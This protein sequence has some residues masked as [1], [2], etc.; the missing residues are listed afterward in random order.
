MFSSVPARDVSHA[1][2]R[3]C[4]SRTSSICRPP[5]WFTAPS[6]DGRT[7]ALATKE[8]ALRFVDVEQRNVVGGP[9]LAG[10]HVRSV[11]WSPDGRHF[12]VNLPG[13]R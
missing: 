12:A 6:P 3:S 2:R 7:I 4:A 5:T 9:L 13:E 11:A 8:R 1:A 10:E